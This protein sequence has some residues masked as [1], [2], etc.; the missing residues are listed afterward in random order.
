[1]SAAA[2]TKA[3][4]SGTSAVAGRPAPASTP[5]RAPLSLVRTLPVRRR[6]PFAVFCLGVLAVALI[7]VLVLNI[8]V[9]SGQYQLVELK[10]QQLSLEQQNQD[11][12][13]RVQNY[14]APQN[15]AA[16]AAQLGMVAATSKGQIDLKTLLVTGQPTPAQKGASQGAVIASP[17]VAGYDATPAPSPSP[18]DALKQTNAAAKATPA[19]PAPKAAAPTAPA[20][21]VVLNGGTVPA[22][23]QR[24]PGQ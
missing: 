20:T 12:Q 19:S 3:M 9:T 14:E 5:Q 7:A 8:S 21:P 17:E 13:Q 22:P 2:Q 1:M 18:S 15:L 6:A 16:R 10:N 23:Q 24:T 4:T 11:L